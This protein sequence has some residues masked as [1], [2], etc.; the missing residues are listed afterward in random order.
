MAWAAGDL[1]EGSAGKAAECSASSEF[2]GT[3]PATKA[4]DGGTS[5]DADDCWISTAANGP[6][7]DGSCYLQWTFSART[8]IAG[9][10]L[11]RRDAA[12]TTNFPN[13]IKVY[14]S[15]TGAFSGEQ[16]L[17]GDLTQVSP[18][19]GAWGDELA[20]TPW[21]CNYLRVEIHS[22]YL[23]GDAADWVAVKEARFKGWDEIDD[24]PVWIAD[25]GGNLVSEVSGTTRDHGY[26]GVY[27]GVNSIQLKYRELKILTYT[28]DFQFSKPTDRTFRVRQNYGRGEAFVL[29]RYPA[30]E[31]NG[32]KLFL[33][34]EIESG[35][36]GDRRIEL[37]DGDYDVSSDTDFVPG[38]SSDAM[39]AAKGVGR[40]AIIDDNP[41]STVP[42]TESIEYT[43][44]TSTATQP[45]VT[46]LI[47]F[48]SGND[49][50][51]CNYKINYW[52]VS[53]TG[54][55][56]LFGETDLG[57]EAAAIMNPN[58]MSAELDL[59]FEVSAAIPDSYFAAEID[60]D[61]PEPDDS[62]L[63]AAIDL[64]MPFEVAGLMAQVYQGAF[65]FIPE[66]EM[67]TGPMEA[68]A[69]HG[70]EMESA[71]L[72]G[73]VFSGG[74]DLGFEALGSTGMSGGADIDPFDLSAA[75][76]AGGLFS[77][78]LDAP[79]DVSGVGAFLAA[80]AGEADFRVPEASG[81][82]IS[83]TEFMASGDFGFEAL[84]LLF[85]GRFFSG[86][87]DVFPVDFEGRIDASAGGE[88]SIDMPFEVAGAASLATATA[89]A[90]SGLLQFN[91]GV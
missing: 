44:D 1:Y 69:E 25:L 73:N 54:I 83:A 74:A 19:D 79:F 61:Y 27:N 51:Y 17:I 76:L 4:F 35:S 90:F 91:R 87:A 53:D 57:H 33:Q 16:V 5:V 65:D 36:I 18:S 72:E 11:R 88:A 37:Y 64:D 48:A 3:Y 21:F 62:D 77:G 68:E 60:F 39:P 82:I 59:G 89:Q 6:A 32:K 70:F 58:E 7:S 86:G 10:Q 24:V 45:Y 41:T 75:L 2:S 13:A 40:I 56:F 20:L 46:V 30:T 42:S 8:L 78:A 52:I 63:S 67:D 50:Y 15:D 85:P 66:V 55:N 38:S 22:M 47:R 29:A 80:M 28:P 34:I 81:V 23:R 26:L 31:V 84:G 9:I 12:A 71:L 43:L 49:G 14:A